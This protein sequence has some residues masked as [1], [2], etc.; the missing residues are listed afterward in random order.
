MVPPLPYHQ[1]D[2]I[3]LSFIDFQCPQA[4]KLKIAILFVHTGKEDKVVMLVV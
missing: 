1:F 2:G 3:N 4:R